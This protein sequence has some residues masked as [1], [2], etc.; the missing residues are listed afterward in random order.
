MNL[1]LSRQMQAVVLAAGLSLTAAACGQKIGVESAL[2]GGIPG[3]V[4]AD[5]TIVPATVNADGT[6]PGA[7]GTSTGG[8]TTGS[9]VSGGGSGAPGSSGPGTTTGGGGTT[10]GSGSGSGD[11]PPA[12]APGAGGGNATGV[13]DTTI[14]IGIH[15]PVTGA[16]A[17]PQTSF[18]R[19]IGTYFDHINQKGG[20]HG[21]KV[22]VSFEDD[23]FRPDT[24]RAKCKK[25]AEQEKVF[26][27]LGAAGSDQIDAC[28]RYAA[29][30]G[31]PYLSGGVH[32]TR[33]GQ[34][35]LSDLSTYF[36]MTMTYEQQTPLLARVYRDHYDGQ[37]VVVVTADNDSL[38][39]YHSRAVAAL[40]S[41]AGSNF[42]GEK[43][44]PKNTTSEAP[45]VAAE[46]CGSGAKAVVWNA[47]P[48]T[49]LN[50][51]K[52]MTCDVGFIGPG[53]TNGLN[54][55]ATVGCDK[56][57]NARFFAS[58]PGMDVMRRDAE[59]VNAYRTRNDAEPDDIGAQAWGSE[60]LIAQILQAVGRDLSRE[61]LMATM[62]RVKVFKSGVIPPTNFTSRLGGTAMHL[63][64]A[65]CSKSE[66]VTEKVNV[67]P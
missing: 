23:Q 42:A 25:L 55:V 2:I 19:A 31:V 20:I 33:H 45:T 16:A 24:A 34:G 21:R 22:Q 58:V 44:I 62:A 50:V 65:D 57:D 60:K 6:I 39:G 4:A 49:L 12:A 8:A 67:A 52:V 47:S 30:V 10:P 40:Q 27:L 17:I 43:R 13:T 14:K 59:F 66:Y 3:T 53:N 35:A 37:K 26:M 56:L 15:A 11:A 18:E 9:G 36:A 61:S 29:A 41:A 32:E 54:I 5:G 1:L 51:S 48:S 38:D 63:L 46:I 64:R 28:A 7:P